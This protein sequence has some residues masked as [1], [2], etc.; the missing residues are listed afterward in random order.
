M[1][2]IRI[3]KAIAE[4]ASVLTD[5]SFASKQYWNYPQSYFEPWQQELTISEDYIAHHDVFVFEEQDRVC[6]YY[7]LVTLKNDLRVGNILLT[8]GTWLEHMFVHPERIGTTIGTQLFTHMHQLL[9]SR[10]VA[11]VNILADPHARLFYE[12]MGCEYAGEFPS[13]I[14]GR[15][16]PC[17]VYQTAVRQ[18]SKLREITVNG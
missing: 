18:S 10:G 6:G 9:E 14:E 4:D 15:T 3:R 8:S 11:E 13:T 1:K 12:K 16:T 2:T 17:L 7:S 5:L